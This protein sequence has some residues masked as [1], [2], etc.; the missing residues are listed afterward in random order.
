MKFNE[1][2]SVHII[3]VCG[4]LMGAFAAYLK[5]S[6][7]AVTGSDQNVYP[8]MSD[9]LK[10][11]GVRLFSGYAAENL[12]S[13]PERPDLVVIGNVIGAVNPEARAAIDGGYAYTSLPEAMEK[14]LLP[15][16]RN[17]VVSGTHGKTTTS[18]MLAHILVKAG[19]NPNYFI[20]GV[21]K[22]LPFSFH[23][24][25]IAPGNF[26]VLEGDEYDTAFWDKVPKFNHYLPDDVILTSVEYDHADIYPDFA[27]VVRAFEGLVGRIRAGGR[28]IACFDYP[29]IRELVTQSRVP[30]LSYGSD[31]AGARFAPAD[32]KI[33]LGE[34]RFKILDSGKIVTELA[35][36]VPGH[37]NVLNALA[38]W[39]ECRE[40]GLSDEQI[41]TGFKSFQGVRRRQE[42]RGE[43]RGVL[44][45]D[46]FAHHP[47]AVRE[48]LRA[49]KGRYQGRPLIAVFEPRS[50]TSRRKVF[51][52]EFVAAFKDADAVFISS[53]YDQS[54]IPAADQFSSEQLV[55][56]LNQNN[57][58]TGII[59]TVEEGVSL[60]AREARPGDVIAVLSNGGFGG[61]IPKLL[62]E[63][64]KT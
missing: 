53:P 10:D 7:I 22:D 18:T 63:L 35:I 56:D 60:V 49:L 12:L 32:V 57:V 5:R 19:K 24:S 52:K 48:T 27:A 31:A 51:Q 13:L 3:G 8:P 47:T 43:E 14:I 16:T 11:A 28:M 38:V 54:K 40:L 2:K 37:H 45:I 17:L 1:I 20:G 46:D 58:K 36:P 55:E 59:Q 64:K 30:V 50:A 62:N 61:F 23:L 21:S 39:I 34:T 6:G 33:G 15:E 44:V 4:T 29:V 9:V 42:E 26:F 25:S 41:S